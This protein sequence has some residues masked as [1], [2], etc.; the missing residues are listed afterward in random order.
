MIDTLPQALIDS[1]R[2]ILESSVSSDN[3]LQALDRY[4]THGHAINN[5]LRSYKRKRPIEINQDTAYPETVNLHHLDVAFNQHSKSATEDMVLYRGMKAHI[6]VPRLYTEE[7]FTSLSTNK[8]VAQGYDD[9]D[10]IVY[11]VHVPKGTNLL[12]IGSHVSDLEDE[13][14]LS[15]DTSFTHDGQGNIH[16]NT[17]YVNYNKKL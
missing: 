11:S 3:Q 1:A 9:K 6:P 12:H 13:I 7:G 4:K 15:R 16:V 10:G 17:K 2:L 5:A 8:Q 14:V